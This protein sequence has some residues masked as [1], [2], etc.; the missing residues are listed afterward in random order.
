[1]TQSAT[2]RTNPD[3]AYDGDPNTGFPVYD[4][5]GQTGGNWL[6]IGG[7][8]AGAPQLAALL[9]ITDQGRALVGKAPLNSSD[10]QDVQKL[11]YA[12]PGDFH[13]ITTGTST[14]SPNYSAGPG[15]DLVT[16]LGTPL[17][18]KLAPDLVGGRDKVDRIG[19]FRP[20]TG[21]WY[22]DTT[23]QSYAQNP[24]QPVVWGA[25]GDV[26]V[27]GDWDGSGHAEIGVFRPST[28]TWYLDTTNQDYSKNPVPGIL[29]GSPGDK[30]VVGNWRPSV[31]A[32]AQARAARL[33]AAATGLAPKPTPPVVSFTVVEPV[34]PVVQ[35]VITDD[36]QL[37]GKPEP[38]LTAFTLPTD[39]SARPRKP[40]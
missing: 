6:Q 9:A 8:S 30:P 20:S 11:L 5:Y 15:Y 4:S 37:V 17:A 16:G 10:P 33:G 2:Q 19:V 35:T 34:A 32:N 29:F 14:G 21:T 12:N 25:T 31:A 28:G 36:L 26:P 23:N 7:T 40:A 22:L 18:P 13:D 1:V 27:V 38:I 24:V 39:R 3:V